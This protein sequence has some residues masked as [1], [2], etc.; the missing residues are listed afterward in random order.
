[1]PV[2]MPDSDATVPPKIVLASAS[3]TRARLLA[4]AGVPV[5][6]HP[7]AID[8]DEIKISLRGAKATSAAAAETLAEIKAQTVSRRCP[9]RLV[10][11]ADQVLDCDEE[12]FDKPADLKQA[13]AQLGR[14]RGRRHELISSAMVVQD[15]VRLWH[16]T[17]RAALT[18]RPFSDAFLDS[19]LAAAGPGVCASVGAYQLEGLGAQLFA[20]VEG[21]YFTILG[22]PLLPL[23]AFL[24]DRDALPS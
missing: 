10:V 21:D 2:T 8:E 4:A 24:R 9:G 13:R 6:T 14:L 17:A 20:R 18:M 5:E 3:A 7:A 19:Y 22:L 11:G 12:W 15:G 23:L 16:H 1:M